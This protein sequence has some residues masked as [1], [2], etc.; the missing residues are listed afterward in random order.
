[1]L[2]FASICPHPPILIPAIGQD[3]LEQIKK[4]KEAMQKLAED[5]YAAQIETVLII[6][7]HGQLLEE[8]FTLNASSKFTAS[9]KKFGD[10]ETELKFKGD[11]TFAYQIKERLET[12]MPLQ[13]TVNQELDHGIGVPLYYLI[14]P[15]LNLEKQIKIIPLGYSYLDLKAHFSLGRELA[16]IIHQTKKRIA[17]VASGDLS[18][19]LTPEAPAGYSESG[20]KFDQKLVEMLKQKNIEGIL[21]LDKNFIE[22]AAECGL[23][24]I[25][26]LLGILNEQNYAPDILSYEGPFGVGYLV[27]N[28]ELN[29]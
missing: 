1:M 29:R 24:S 9:F 22:S 5:F 13:L 8:S 14:Q 16:E 3:N 15:L 10:L 12:K 18:H 23:K 25:V 20:K 28:F 7:P 6:S 2:V 4:T 11:P 19:A 27:C 21:N 26:I 17:V